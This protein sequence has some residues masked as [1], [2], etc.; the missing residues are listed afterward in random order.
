[1]NPLALFMD[2]YTRQLQVTRASIPSAC[3]LSTLGL[4]NFPNARFVSLKEIANDAFV[5]TGPLSSRKGLEIHHSNKVALTFWWAETE[6]QVR[7]QGEATRIPDKLADKY[8]AERSQE[9]QVVSLVSR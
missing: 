5:V 8:F 4:D 9:A 7:I 3:C 6:R 2:W 1:M